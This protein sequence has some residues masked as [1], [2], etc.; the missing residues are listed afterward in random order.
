MSALPPKAD[1]Y[2]AQSRCLLCANSGHGRL[3]QHP[4]KVEPLALLH[5]RRIEDD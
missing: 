3:D 5:Q 1:I 2:A 4:V